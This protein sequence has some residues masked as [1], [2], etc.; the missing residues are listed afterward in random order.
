M[1]DIP[2]L[3]KVYADLTDAD[4][5]L[6]KKDV[7]A[8]P[9]ASSMIKAAAGEGRET[10]TILSF[11]YGV[12]A[13]RVFCL[14]KFEQDVEVGLVESCIRRWGRECS[15]INKTPLSDAERT[16]FLVGYM[17]CLVAHM[18]DFNDEKVDR[19][20]KII[21]TTSEN[22]NFDVS[23]GFLKTRARF[24]NHS[25]SDSLGSK[26]WCVFLKCVALANPTNAWKLYTELYRSCREF[27]SDQFC[28]ILAPIIF[29]NETDGGIEV[30]YVT[31]LQDSDYYANL[32]V[33]MHHLR[34]VQDPATQRTIV[35]YLLPLIHDTEKLAS[36]IDEVCVVSNN[37]CIV[38]ALP[39]DVKQKFRLE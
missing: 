21:A 11:Y 20:V 31:I 36:L 25:D 3:P 10:P 12:A 18:T 28:G 4:T 34:E 26:L 15:S 37:R 27:D 6:S 39:D 14:S 38:R 9:V 7:A 22:F 32:E 29:S 30:I 2:P 13:A 16:E 33:L 17:E 24:W 23:V 1:G 8:S 19:V 35:T 5:E